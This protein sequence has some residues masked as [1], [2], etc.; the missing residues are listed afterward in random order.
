MDYEV[1]LAPSDKIKNWQ[2]NLDFAHKSEKVW[3][4]K[5]SNKPKPFYLTFVYY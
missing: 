3:T 5:K 1:V 2:K 4:L